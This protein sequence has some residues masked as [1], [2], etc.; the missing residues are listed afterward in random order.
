MVMSEQS[1]DQT[2]NKSNNLT[3]ETKQFLEKL[4]GHLYFDLAA[5]VAVNA[6]TVPIVLIELSRR[7]AP[8]ATAAGIVLALGSASLGLDAAYQTSKIGGLINRLS[9]NKDSKQK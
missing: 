2:E 6:L 3:E 8:E 9:S 5:M 4:K 7:F 1:A